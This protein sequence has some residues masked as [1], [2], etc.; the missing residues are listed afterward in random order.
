MMK[1]STKSAYYSVYPKVVK[2]ESET[3]ITIQGLYAHSRFEEGKIYRVFVDAAE[4]RT[5]AVRYM[6]Q[7]EMII[8][9]KDG[10]LKILCRFECEQEYQLRVLDGDKPVDTFCVYAVEADLYGRFP[11]KGD[12]HMHT[13]RSDGKEEP[14]FVA[15]ACREIGMDFIAITDHR[16]YG[17]ALEAIEKFQGVPHDLCLYRGE[18][19]H[20]PKELLEGASED[21]IRIRWNQVPVHML[22]INGQF[23]V[24]DLFLKDE[25][26]F[27]KE[28]ERMME[29]QTVPAGVS[30]YEYA[31]CTWAFQKVRE[32]DGLS[33]F[34]H[35]MWRID[36]GYYNGGQITD[37]LFDTMP[38]DAYEVVSG[39]GPWDVESNTLQVSLYHQQCMKKGRYIPIVGVSDSHGT[40]ENW[41]FGWYYTIAFAASPAFEDV[42]ESIRSCR[43]VAVEHIPGGD[44]RA[45][46]P[47]RLVKFSLFLNREVLPQHDCL[48]AKEGAL[49]KRHCAGEDVS[50]QLADCTGGVEKYFYK[51]WG[52]R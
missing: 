31:A 11:Y 10:A 45:Y 14:A 20:P 27:R 41:L 9:G 48:C 4:R 40:E 22:N 46:G 44:L 8:A 35:P 34:C 43:S 32:G 15:A 17:G 29:G 5:R 33:V 7:A 18:E 24:N 1:K 16:N 13:C 49:M 42:A 21:D 12:L 6:P 51:M 36:K 19:I 25:E 26:G 2:T 52:I 30:P 37:Y 23:S 3:E 47:H 28:I 39:Y 50:K 38:F